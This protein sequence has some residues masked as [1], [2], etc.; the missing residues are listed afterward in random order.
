M[1]PIEIVSGHPV[2]EKTT[3]EAAIKIFEQWDGTKGTKPWFR[4]LRETPSK[5]LCK[6]KF[7]EIE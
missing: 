1:E 3:R 6:Y 7:E 5:E 4:S 2:Y